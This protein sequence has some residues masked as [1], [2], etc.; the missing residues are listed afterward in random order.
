MDIKTLIILLKNKQEE[1][2]NNYSSGLTSYSEGKIDGLNIAIREIESNY[3]EYIK[4]SKEIMEC[5]KK[6]YTQ[7]SEDID[8]AVDTLKNMKNKDLKSKYKDFLQN[9]K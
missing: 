2:K 6:L 5:H 7:E 4:T 1:I 3:A 9:S 8:R